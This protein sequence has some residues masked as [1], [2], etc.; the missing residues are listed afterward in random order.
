MTYVGRCVGGPWHGLR[1][2]N[3]LPT[4]ELL[5]PAKS[6]GF[7]RHNKD[8]WIWDGCEMT[9]IYNG[10]CTGG[11]LDGKGLTHDKPRKFLLASNN[12]GLQGEYVYG[13]LYGWQWH[14]EN[15]KQTKD[16]FDGPAD[17]RQG[18][19]HT[20]PG[21]FAKRYKAQSD[22]VIE[23]TDAIKDKAAELEELMNR[24]PPSREASLAMTSL[25]LTV[26]WACKG[27]FK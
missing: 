6:M 12:D 25:E 2:A 13:D 19:A 21:R 9:E 7:Y 17:A 8:E 23:L 15:E 27:L 16:L 18:G 3:H 14:D 26:F 24:A 22:E 20:K 5:A 11:P 4:H 1:Y 10:V